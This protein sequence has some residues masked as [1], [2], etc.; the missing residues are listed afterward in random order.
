MDETKYHDLLN[1]NVCLLKGGFREWVN[2]YGDNEKYV[3]DFNMKHWN[4]E[5]VG[6]KTELYHKNDW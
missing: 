6:G 1:Q 5:E 4:Y 3:E 2:A